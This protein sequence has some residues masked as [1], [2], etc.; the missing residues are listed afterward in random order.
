MVC[1]MIKFGDPAL[2]PFGWSEL[3]VANPDLAQ[4]V[5]GA[6]PEASPAFLAE[7]AR[8]NAHVND[9]VDQV[10]NVDPVQRA[11]SIKPPFATP[12][13]AGACCDLAATKWDALG[14]LGVPTAF[15]L[16]AEVI[17]PE[18]AATPGLHHLVCVVRA[19][20]NGGEIALV[21]DN[22]VPNVP[23]CHVRHFTPVRI[24][25]PD[26]PNIWREFSEA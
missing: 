13:A 11:W 24:Q 23:E 4:P 26:G 8:V 21:L 3:L 5:A 15:R 7:L 20:R 22:L 18:T 25:S 16:L 1:S 12:P 10:L 6:M 9:G 14:R 19:R 17:A 2:P